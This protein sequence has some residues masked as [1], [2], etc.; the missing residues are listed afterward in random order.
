MLIAIVACAL[1]GYAVY[2][3]RSVKIQ[4]AGGESAHHEAPPPEPVIPVYV[5]LDAFTVSLKP[6]A[7]D[8]DR[9]LYIGLTLR[10]KDE[11]SRGFITEFLPEVRSRLLM[12]FSERTAEELSMQQGKTQLLADIKQISNKPFADG[13]NAVVTDV[14]LNDFI[15]R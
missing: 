11:A 14:L 12:L 2:E 6:V 15:L 4:A 7:T 1:A 8:T 9:V 3:L 10:V 5:P 13:K